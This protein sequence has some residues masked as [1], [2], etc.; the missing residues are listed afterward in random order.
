MLPDPKDSFVIGD[1][2]RQEAEKKWS[3][4]KADG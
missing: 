4:K 3:G 2:T 1:M